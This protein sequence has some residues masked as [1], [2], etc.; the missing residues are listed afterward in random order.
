M[1]A[2][3][4]QVSI[5][6]GHEEESLEHLRTNVVPRVKQAPGV[7]AGYW[8]GPKDGHGM[9]VTIWDSEEAARNSIEMARNAPRPD[10]VTFDGFE[11]RE[12]IGN[13]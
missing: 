3:V 1:H 2:V 10:S 4:A 8:L 7:V 12:V 5:Q 11:V 13:V 6:S 9:A